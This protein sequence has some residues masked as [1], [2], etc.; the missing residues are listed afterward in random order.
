MSL[1]PRQECL[2]IL[3]WNTIGRIDFLRIEF[4]GMRKIALL[5]P[6]RYELMRTAENFTNLESG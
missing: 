6:Q 5:N 2:N 1:T 3:A 4:I